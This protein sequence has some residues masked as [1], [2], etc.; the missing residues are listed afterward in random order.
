[1]MRSNRPSVATAAHKWHVRA[2][3]ARFARSMR[4]P[5]F[6]A[7]VECARVRFA[8]RCHSERSIRPHHYAAFLKRCTRMRSN[9]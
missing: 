5:V 3:H 7:H 8:S 2:F 6:G 1:M 9:R 4:V